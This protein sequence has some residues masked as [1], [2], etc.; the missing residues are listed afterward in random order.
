MLKDDDCIRY[1][2]QAVNLLNCLL[3]FF[4]VQNFAG[5]IN[6]GSKVHIRY[7]RLPIR[8]I[9]ICSRSEYIIF[10]QRIWQPLFLL[11]NHF[12]C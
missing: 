6:V 2:G 4:Y 11:P 12:K 7:W 1:A 10:Q 9:H 3:G 8:K 5:D